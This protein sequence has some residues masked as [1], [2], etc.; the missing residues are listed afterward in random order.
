VGQ[1]SYIGNGDAICLMTYDFLNASSILNV[2]SQLDSFSKT[3]SRLKLT[4]R[5][6]V[7]SI[8]GQ[9]E[10]GQIHARVRADSEAP[11]DDAPKYIR[12]VVRNQ[13]CDRDFIGP[14]LDG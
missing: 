7:R 4:S 9:L 6:I 1:K 5:S 14:V 11:N 3:A 13:I 10:L 12:T 8:F 2:G